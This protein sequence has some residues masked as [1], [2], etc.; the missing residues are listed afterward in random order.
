MYHL[1]RFSHNRKLGGLPAS[2]S[3]SSTCPT[4][5]PLKARGCYAHRGPLSW[6][7]AKVTAGTLGGSWSQFVAAVRALPRGILWRYG[8][9]GDLPGLGDRLDTQKLRD[10]ATAN[11]GRKGFTYSHKPLDRE[12]ERQ[13]VSQAIRDGFMINLSADSLTEADQLS[14]L[15]IAPVAVVVPNFEDMPRKTP[16][17]RFLTPCPEESHKIPCSVCQLCSK[18]RNSIVAFAARGAEKNAITW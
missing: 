18:P 13:A 7:W 15:G 9:A 6:Q 16:A 12:E 2:I 1:V 11:R 3:T 4:S 14:E 5:C 10:L 17:G 8:E